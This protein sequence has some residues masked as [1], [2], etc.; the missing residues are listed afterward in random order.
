MLTE[1]ESMRPLLRARSQ[2]F[3]GEF[4]G[5]SCIRR[6]LGRGGTRSGRRGGKNRVI[7]SLKDRL[8]RHEEVGRV[9][10]VVK[11]EHHLSTS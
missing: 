3:N 2:G 5:F 10:M 11:K 9:D 8:S 6:H 7:L 1:V 4:L